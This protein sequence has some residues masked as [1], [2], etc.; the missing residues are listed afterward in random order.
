MLERVSA[1]ASGNALG[2][3]VITFAFFAIKGILWL[4][5]PF[6]ILRWQRRRLSRKRSNNSFVGEVVLPGPSDLSEQPLN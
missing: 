5:V 3:L 1:A 4:V 2:I 6:L